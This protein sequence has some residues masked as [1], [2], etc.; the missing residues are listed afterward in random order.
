MA[1]IITHLTL[2]VLAAFLGYSVITKIPA[3][4]HTPLMSGANAITGIT[5]VG[6]VVVAGSGSTTVATVLGFLAVVM[7][8]INVVG[9]YL[10]SHFMLEDFHGGGR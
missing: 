7:A 10:V 5:L 1:D 9:G 2:F 8:T 6:A 4:L 3:T